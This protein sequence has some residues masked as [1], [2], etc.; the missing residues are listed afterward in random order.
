MSCVHISPPLGASLCL[1][2]YPTLQVITQH[3]DG[4]PVLQQLPTSYPFHARQCTLVSPSLPTRPPLPPHLCPY[5]HSLNV[6]ISIPARLILKASKFLALL[7]VQKVLGERAYLPL[8]IKPE[9]ALFFKSLLLQWRNL[10][11]RE[12]QSS[13]WQRKEKK[14]TLC[15]CVSSVMLDSL[16]LHGL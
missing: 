14:S 9:I 12:S 2:P 3:W 5:V 7:S 11:L 13:R 1:L 10:R 15:M 8:A 4:L 16:R 6:R